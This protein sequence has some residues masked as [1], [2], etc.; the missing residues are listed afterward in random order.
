MYQCD[1]C[2][3]SNRFEGDFTTVSAGE[4]A[5]DLA[6]CGYDIETARL[7]RMYAAEQKYSAG[8]CPGIALEQGTMFPELMSE[9]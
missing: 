5:V 7:P 4:V 9:Y 6:V 2:R 3:L 1:S 8:L